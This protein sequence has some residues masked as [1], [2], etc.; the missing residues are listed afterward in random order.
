MNTDY[1]SKVIQTQKPSLKFLISKWKSR[2]KKN[3]TTNV[4]YN[5][6][7]KRIYN[8]EKEKEFR[9]KHMRTLNLASVWRTGS[10]NCTKITV[11]CNKL[12]IKKDIVKSK[13]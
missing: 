4:S 8:S 6:A 1:H 2:N 11:Q 7:F 12:F 10:F 5:K 13:S 3:G 9:Y